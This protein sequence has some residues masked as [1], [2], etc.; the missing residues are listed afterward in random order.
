[1]QTKCN[2]YCKQNQIGNEIEN[3]NII[4]NVN[5]IENE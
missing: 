2:L 3:E 1:M 5:T 4:E